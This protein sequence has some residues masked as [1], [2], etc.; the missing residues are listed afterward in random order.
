MTA[1]AA[2]CITVA[3]TGFPFDRFILLAA[4][5]LAAGALLLLLGWAHRRGRA[6]GVVALMVLAVGAAVIAG[7]SAANA[8]R[9]APST[10]SQAALTIT[11]TSTNIGLAPSVAPAGITGRITNTGNA[12]TFVRSVTVSIVGIVKAPGARPGSCTASD[13]TLM[14][15]TMHVARTLHRG[16]SANFGGAA[17]GFRSTAVNQDACQRAIVQLRFIS[18]GQ[19]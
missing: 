15:P 1:T 19:R 9:C 3:N 14:R 4:I 13:Y 11:Q 2:S 12:N 8:D 5:C 6:V 16:E 18:S 17:I 10:N 7:A